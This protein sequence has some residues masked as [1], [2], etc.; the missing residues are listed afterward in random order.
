MQ[1]TLKQKIIIP[2]WEI[3]QEHSTLKKF[4]FLPGLLS[5]IFLSVL[6]VYQAIYTYVEVFGYKEEAFQVILGFFHSSYAFE[7][8]V[9]G[10]IFFLVYIVIAPL[11]EGAMIKYIESVN[12][13]KDTSV[14]DALGMGIYRFLP[15][16]EY[17][18]IFSEFKLISILNA[19]LFMIRF[20]G[21]EYISYLSGV[22]VFVFIFSVV[23]NILFSY[24]KYFIVVENKKVFP[25]IS[26][27]S[28]LA[29]LNIS[30]T[31]RIYFL[32]FLLNMRVVFNFLIFLSFPLLMV[33]AVSLIT[34]KIY[35][36][37][38]IIF[39][40]V[41]FSILILALGYLTAVLEIF[42]TALWYFAYKHGKQKTQNLEE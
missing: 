38:A 17:N 35:L 22:F 36:A 16:F 27:S 39:L 18:N 11:F 9:G 32:M 15:L 2:A 7:A 41:V 19:Y 1:N 14:G 23:L 25:A 13:E 31:S 34:S 5:I 42:K 37:I 29:I 21:I 4:Y 3:I 26:A 12:N 8:I 20:L 28:K 40:S 6:L 30:I 24:S 10:I 33:V